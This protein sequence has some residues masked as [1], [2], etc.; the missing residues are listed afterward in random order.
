MR[1]RQSSLSA[2]GIAAIRALESEKPEGERLLYDPYARQFV[3][4]WLYAVVRVFDRLGWSERK[5]PG[6]VGFL[7]TRDR[8]ID[9]VLEARLAEGI[10]QLVILGAGFDARAYRFD[11]LSRDVH[12]FEVDH[13]ASQGVKL[14]RLRRIL[15]CVPDH[16]TFVA[17]DFNTQSLEER[18]PA[19]GYD[20]TLR[21]LFIWQGVTHYLTPEAV[22]ATLSFVAHHSG[23]GSSIV[24]DYIE[25]RAL[26]DTAGHGEVKGM[27]DHQWMSGEALTFGIPADAIEA[28]L[29][30]RGFCDVV[31]VGSAGLAARYFPDGSGEVAPD[32][33]IVAARICSEEEL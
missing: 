31:N 26:A 16:V 18:L 7:V 1:K 20:P 4:G 10:D 13:P 32:Y 2:L 3:P 8:Y 6:V 19:E 23:P 28:F 12:V 5:G 27:R 11:A 29:Q 22:D 17:I 33:G 14:R 24:F 15:G 21:T 25:P 9:D 30:Q